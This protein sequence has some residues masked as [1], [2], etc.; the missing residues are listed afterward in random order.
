MKEDGGREDVHSKYTRM[1]MLDPGSNNGF[2]CLLVLPFHFKTLT[3]VKIG[4]QCFLL[5][6]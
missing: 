4:F 6:K 5:A 2:L 3:I 1:E